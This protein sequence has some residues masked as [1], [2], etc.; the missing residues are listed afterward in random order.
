[1]VSP[2]SSLL[3]LLLVLYL[4]LLLLSSFSHRKKNLC[5]PFLW[6]GFNFLKATATSRRQF[7]F[8]HKVPRNLWYSFYQLQKD[9]RLSRL[10]S[11]PVV[12]NMGPLDWESSHLT[13]RPLFWWFCTLCS[14]IISLTNLSLLLFMILWYSIKELWFILCSAGHTPHTLNPPLYK[15]RDW[16]WGDFFPGFQA[17]IP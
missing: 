13:T 11:H 12:L 14:C 4:I 5:G 1:M 17:S 9:G 6:M 8:Y 10:C 2:I 3:L 7:T 16:L 15:R